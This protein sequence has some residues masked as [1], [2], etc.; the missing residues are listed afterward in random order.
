MIGRHA[1]AFVKWDTLRSGPG[2]HPAF[3]ANFYRCDDPHIHKLDGGGT[4]WVVTSLKNSE[5]K[6]IRTLA[7]KLA[8]CMAVPQEEIGQLPFPELGQYA[9][10]A[11]DA[12]GTHHFSFKRTTVHDFTSELMALRFTNKKPIGSED[13]IGFWLRGFPEPTEESIK[14]LTWMERKL[15]YGR[16]VVVS[17]AREDK[18]GAANLQKGL[19]DRGLTV[20][21]DLTDLPAGENWRDA[22]QDTLRVT[23]A[24]VVLLSEASLASPAVK[25]EIRWAHES[26]A[27][28]DGLQGIF[29]LLLLG[30][31]AD[32]VPWDALDSGTGPER[33]RDLNAIKLPA[34]PSAA[35]LDRLALDIAQVTHERMKVKK[36]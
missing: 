10:I 35:F 12:E 26:Y 34:R 20:W 11:T 31:T 32:D 25:D 19:Q 23:D 22:V 29:L 28:L 16:Q 7:Y 6:R 30:I 14:L 4:L 27:R 18:Q 21:R 8:G 9:V 13:K 1:L 15:R 24:F 36:R 3:R 5:E 17:Y 33:L 2:K